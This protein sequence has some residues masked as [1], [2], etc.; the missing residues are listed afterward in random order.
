MVER[1]LP[2]FVVIGAQKAGS[3]Y[4]ADR[5]G[6]VDGVFV[7][8]L[9]IPYFEAPFF[10]N[11]D[12][13][14]LWRSGADAE[15]GDLFGL[16]R[17]DYLARPEVPGNLA[18]VVPGAVLIAVLRPPIRRTV[19]AVHWYMLHGQ[20]PAIGLNA[21]LRRILDGLRAGTLTGPGAEIVANGL[22]A[23]ALDRYLKVWPAERLVVIDSR[24]VDD[25]ETYR[26]LAEPLALPGS[27]WPATTG[28][29][30]ANSGVYNRHR[31]R[32]LRMRN[33]LV[34]DWTK[35]SVFRYK[36]KPAHYRPVRA[37]LAQVPKLIDRFAV[38]R[39]VDNTPEALDPA[40][41]TELEDIFAPDLDRL[42]EN[43]QI[44]LRLD[45]PARSDGQGS[46]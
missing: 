13:Q 8:Q 27:T 33:G 17:A 23:E 45:D 31:L 28:V 20:L 24:L 14:E 25:Q 46:P 36:R 16:K 1:R 6:E 42:A 32:L 2:D 15:P 37:S 39:F 43:F 10:E 19:S 29:S 21:N 22:Y 41:Q 30:R 18:A 40:V 35:D 3:T 38:Q 9:E 26:R 34:Y 4:L 7:P 44:D 11:S 5:L 12:E